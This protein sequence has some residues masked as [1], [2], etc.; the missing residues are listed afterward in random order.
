MRTAAVLTAAGSGSR[1]GHRLPKAL[2]PLDGTPLLTHA[3]RRLVASGGVDVL[4]VT[5]P[6]GHDAA[7]RA[8]LDDA[9][10]QGDGDA[11]AVLVVTGGP[12]R[13]ASVAAALAVLPADVD[14]VLVHDAARALVPP[15]LVRRVVDAVRS[16]NPAV[17]PALVVTDT[18]VE[19]G[20]GVLP[21]DAGRGEGRDPAGR[22]GRA[23]AEP[24][25]LPVARTLDRAALRAVQT[26]QGFDRA[27]LDEAHAAA[28]DRA[29][30]ERV[31][32][33]DDASLVALL[34]RPVVA[35][36]GDERALKITSPRDLALAHLVLDQGAS[37]S[38]DEPADQPDDL[39]R[40]AR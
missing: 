25:V 5:V 6:D 40:A 1:L 23:A 16:G 8:A 36:A 18:V 9:V 35:V 38:A 33:T 24:L 3:A 15:S 19:V 11:V 7:F 20:V 26:P 32:A 14:V 17:I 39:A 29:H 27:V 13:Q 12:S 21:V 31:A 28:A 2:V 34:G 30:D 4:V 10:P 22:S 37:S